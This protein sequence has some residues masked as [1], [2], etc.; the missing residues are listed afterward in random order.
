MASRI[1]LREESRH[2][3]RRR[4]NHFQARCR[5]RPTAS[6]RSRFLRPAKSCRRL[7]SSMPSRMQRSSAPT[8]RRIISSARTR[9]LPSACAIPVRHECAAAER[10]DATTAAERALMQRLLLKRLQHR[11][12]PRRQYGR[13]DGRLVSQGDQDGSGFEGPQVSNRWIRAGSRSCR[14]SA[15]VPQQTRRQ[16]TFIPRL[17]KGTIDA[18]EWVGPY[19]DEKLGLLQGRQELLLPRLVGRRP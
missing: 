12:F 8:P 9:R 15:S 17:K 14:S 5:E 7:A 4:R 18:A 3:L 19:D 16:A 13:A 1:E 10:V 2:D 6:S 11:Q